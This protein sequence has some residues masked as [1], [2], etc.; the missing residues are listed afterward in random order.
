[1]VDGW[2]VTAQDI[3]QWTR[4]NRRQAQDTLPLLVRKLVLASINPSLLSFPAGDSVLVG[5]WDGTLS[6]DE[7][8]AFIPVGDS[9]WEFGTNARI[10]EKA[11]DDYQ[12]R[13]SNPQGVDTKET[14]FV[15]VTSQRWANREDWVREKNSENQWAQVRGLNADDLE[16]WLEQCPAVHRWFA[17]LIGKRPEGA[18]DIEQAWSDWSYATKPQCNADLVLAGRQ[19]QANELSEQFKAEPSAI[20]VSGESQEE[21]YAFALAVI[22]KSAEFSS[23]FLVV[24]DSKEWDILIDSQQP[25]ILIPQ[26]ADS[27]SLGLAAQR[28][29]WVILPASYMQLA[30]RQPGIALSKADRNQQIKAL[31]A[32]GLDEN[33]AKDVVRSSRG[34]LNPIRRHRALAPVDHQQPEWVIP[35][36]AGPLVAA[37]L[38]GTWNAD[39]KSDC[40]KLAQLADIP[41][42]EFEQHLHR[43]AI[44]SD[45]PIRPVG[46][47]WQMTSRQ[48][49]WSLLSRFI[50]ASVLKRL[51]EVVKEVL[52]EIDPRFEMPPKE[53]WLA[54]VRGKVTKHSRLLRHGLA[55]MLAILASYG[56]RDC[57][58]VGT[59]SVQD[60]VSIWVRQ[61]LIEDVSGQRWGS[62]A[63]E[64]PLLAEAA[65]EIFMEAL[66]TDLQRD[67]PPVTELFVE[68]GYMG[69]CLHAGLL[70]ALEGIS[71]R[72]EYLARVVHILAKLA[73]LD[74][75][76]RYM[77]RPSN[78]LR[79]IFQGWLPQTKAPL[80]ERLKIIDSLIRSEPES[81][82]KLLLDLLP[83]RAGGISTPI[84]RPAFRDWDEGWKAGVTQKEYYQHIVAIADRILKHVNEEPN[85]RWLEVVKKLP[86]LPKG[87]LDSAVIQ[88]RR[89]IDSAVLTD[90]AANEIQDELR[91]TVSRHRTFSDAKWALPKKAVDQLDGLYQSLIPDDLITRYKFL[92]DHPFPHLSDPAPHRDHEQ[93]QKLIE[94]ARID[95]LEK[96]W[97]AL[98][99]SGI[100]RLA[101]VAKLPWSVGSSLDKSSFADKI[102]D[103]VLGWLDNEN[104]SLVQTAMAYVNARYRQTPEWLATIRKQYTG[105][106]SDKTWATFCLGLP[107]REAL[108]DF[109][110]TLTEGAKKHY[111]ENVTRYYLQD[112]DAKYANWV[113]RKLLARRRPLAAIDAAAQYLYTIARDTG[114]NGDLLARVLELAATDPADHET[115]PIITIS[116]DIVKVLKALQS[117]PD[118]DRKRLARIEWM[119]V[120]IFRHNDIQPVTLMDEVLKDPMFFVRLICLAFKG[121]PP[122]EEE[123]SNLSPELRKRQAENAWHL[124][125]LIDRLPGQ[126]DNQKVSAAQLQ[127]W[128]EKVRE[129][130]AKRNRIVIGDEYIGKLLSHSP[131]GSDGIWP[132]QAVRDLLERYESRNIERGIE[133]GLYNQRGLTSR[134]LSEGGKQERELAEKYQHQ[135]DEVKYTWPRT[136]AMLRRIA[137]SYKRDATRWDLEDEL[138]MRFHWY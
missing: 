88:L 108:F 23:R 89:I 66:E 60:Q 117:N 105:T 21:A 10:N 90:I 4:T 36:H 62:L 118:I 37:L 43:W 107:F 98:Q 128:T 122:I 138:E 95:A 48:D 34:Y 104:S 132:H 47:V 74:P 78:T 76:G 22:K 68:E 81:G 115:T 82:W 112:E 46:N 126:S 96:M 130:C 86:Q 67:N 31:V 18:W 45:P 84:H 41:Y 44:A 24:K 127:E 2:R 57:K 27:P 124:L 99:A 40:D 30:G 136:A 15:F 69:G 26:F 72:L 12:K 125:E 1:M 9:I 33:T 129:E 73:R 133:V 54:N 79:E 6:A 121:D 83:E 7:G 56:D 53:R 71:W 38:G 5:G 134:A 80:D 131:P 11:N 49:A 94:E 137:D 100:E 92:F 116:Y 20:R 101:A 32:M 19:D 50:N 59:R 13:T 42:S 106:W 109:L 65:P 28:G 123:F 93:R 113:I 51:G 102:E 110:D 103:L 114:L 85:T 14:T 91:E 120:R 119:Y 58:N 64:L 77:N 52:Q 17:R 61:L 8:T 111:W 97:N 29:H 39:N 135:A 25:L 55:E 75:G 3:T 87:S 70:W 16:T 35:Q 63:G